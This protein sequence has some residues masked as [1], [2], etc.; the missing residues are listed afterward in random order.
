MNDSCCN[1]FNFSNQPYPKVIHCKEIK[2][3]KL[4]KE[5]FN[6]TNEQLLDQLDM[7]LNPVT[8]D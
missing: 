5:T 1:F 3:I 8:V 4:N 7:L 6:K 2:N